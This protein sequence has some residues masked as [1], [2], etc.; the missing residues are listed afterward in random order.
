MNWLKEQIGLL[1]QFLRSD[2]RRVV[3]FCTLG[4]VAA[5]G[6]GAVLSVLF[7][8]LVNQTLVS[9][10][11]QVAEA[12]VVDE[13]GNLSVF[14][15]LTNN[16][17]AMLFSA[18]YGFIPFLFL[19]LLSLLS[20]GALLGMLGALYQANGLSMWYLLAGILP[21][22]IFEMPALVL[23]IACGIYLCRNMCRLVTSSSKRIP[24][25]ELLSD[26]LRVLL[27]V[28]LPLTVVAAFLECYVT[29]AVL[30]MFFR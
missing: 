5:V 2:F 25:V 14:A 23:S 4:M 1:W 12:G 24:M 15:L 6:V 3:L 26:L 27:L 16:W 11:E 17:M 29:P 28:V 10:M 22:G 21:H 8:D 7:P 20:N 18:A 13:A 19:P 30:E 9:F